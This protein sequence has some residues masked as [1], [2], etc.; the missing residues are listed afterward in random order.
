MTSR[1][2][3]SFA[4][5]CGSR[6]IWHVQRAARVLHRHTRDLLLGDAHRAQPRQKALLNPGIAFSAVRPQVTLGADIEREHHLIEVP[7]SDKA[8]HVLGAHLITGIS[9]TLI[10]DIIN[11]QVNTSFGDP[12]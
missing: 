12:R 9:V 5:G 2:P 11:A 8:R 10:A 4:S 3:S 1:T 7:G 6:D